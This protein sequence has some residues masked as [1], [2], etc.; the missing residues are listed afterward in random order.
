MVTQLIIISSD[1]KDITRVNALASDFKYSSL[2]FDSV[3][4]FSDGL[5]SFQEARCVILSVSQVQKQEEVA[6]MVQ[7]VRQL[8]PE[9]FII[10]V[11]GRKMSSENAAFVKKSGCNIVVLEDEFLNTSQVDYICSQVIRSTYIPV[12][13][14]EFLAQTQVNFSLYYMMPLNKKI[15]PLVPSG[16]VLDESRIKKM[17]AAGELL[18]K[19]EEIE[20]FKK[21]V[22]ANPVLGPAGLQSRCRAHYLHF[23]KGHADLVFLLS[24]QSESTSFQQ[25]EK[26]F[27]YCQVLAEGLLASLSSVGDPWEIVDTT[28]LGD[29]GT[30][31]RAPSVAAYAGVLS[32]LGSVGDPNQVMIGALLADLGIIKLP[33]ETLRKIR[34]LKSAEILT[35]LKGEELKSY[36]QHP[37]VGLNMCLG[38]KLQLDVKLR[39]II[40]CTH[41]RVD[42]K[43]FPGK[44]LPE[45]IPHEAMALQFAQMI[46]QEST[47]RLG[48]EKVQANKA[49]KLVFERNMMEK[50]IFDLTFLEKIKDQI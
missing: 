7:V 9:T 39:S 35:M 36:I 49:R 29:F 15:V 22:E 17:Q 4:S 21:Y 31:E 3:D 18:V 16:T 47:V 38:R 5:E 20:L 10:T 14:A 30:L 42:G 40:M 37:E 48:Q 26:L 43:G 27:K 6:G 13:S 34:S 50:G 12:K 8:L 41:E 25:G 24:D 28:S 2:S 45:K 32:L 11:I 19:R 46:E 1:P 33:P 23:C 44:T